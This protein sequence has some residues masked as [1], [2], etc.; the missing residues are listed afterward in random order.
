[1]SKSSVFL[2]GADGHIEVRCDNCKAL[3]D[4]VA[5]ERAAYSRAS[6]YAAHQCEI[7]A[8]CE[9]HLIENVAYAIPANE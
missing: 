1:M 5:N 4:R 8:T 7:E 9:P 2:T 3:I 6:L